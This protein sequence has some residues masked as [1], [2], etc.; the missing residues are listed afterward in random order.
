MLVHF[1]PPPAESFHE[2][3]VYEPEE[4]D[5]DAKRQPGVQGRAE[6]HGVFGPP[7]ARAAL[8]PV[9]EDVADQ[10]P[11]GEV[12][13]GGGGDPGH[14]AEDDGEVDLADEAVLL[15]AGVEPQRDGED[16]AEGEAPDQGAIHGGGAEE[17]AHADNTPQDRAVEVH[18]SNGAGESVDGL[19]GAQALHVGKHPVQHA[20]LRD[21]GHE[22]GDDLD[23]EHDAW[24]DLHV[25][26]QFEVGGE[27]DALRR[28]DVA[29][30]DEDHVGDGAAGEDGA[31]DELADE[32]DAAMLVCDGHDY[33]VWYEED[34]AYGE[35]E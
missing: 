13:A 1:R 6:C 4:D 22:R 19:A 17:L 12:E 16:G 28:G 11:D 3:R 14:G 20:N 15:A 31:A 30:G 18:P 27:L 26:A 21:R 5:D 7:G 29:V 34:G 10:G 32:V 35:G 9:V 24:G 25:V 2:A 23:G 33:A 8:D